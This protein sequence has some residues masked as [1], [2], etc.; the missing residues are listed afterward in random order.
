MYFHYRR[1]ILCRPMQCELIE[2]GNDAAFVKEATDVLEK[3]ISAALAKA[4]RCILALSGGTTPLPVYAALAERPLEWQNVWVFLADER[5]VSPDHPESNQKA[6]RETLL[7]KVNLPPAQFV[8]PDTWKSL[9]EA[10]HLYEMQLRDLLANGPPDVAVLGM[11]EDGHI[12]SLFPPLPPEGFEQNRL[13]IATHKEDLPTADRIT[14]TLPL[15]SSAVLPVFLL[16]GR[17]KKRIWTK[18]LETGMNSR[19]WPAHAV[20]ATGRAVVIAE[21]SPTG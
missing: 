21:W 14:V 2:T 10:V 9:D 19:E 1:A 16:R 18:M 8:V 11:G 15:L 17:A 5:Y 7:S 12:G 4:G 3:A 6:I 13:V 20:L